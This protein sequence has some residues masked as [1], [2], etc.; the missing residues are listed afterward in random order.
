MNLSSRNIAFTGFVHDG[1][2]IALWQADGSGPEPAAT[3]HTFITPVEPITA[4][5]Y[6]ASRDYVDVSARGGLCATGLNGEWPRFQSALATA[7]RDVRDLVIRLP[8]T[9]AG[10]DREG[11]DWFFRD[12][13]ET[14]F[15]QPQAPLPLSLQANAL[16]EFAPPRLV[17]TEDYRNARD[18]SDV[19]ISLVSDTVAVRPAPGALDGPFA[20]VVEGF[21]ADLAG[22]PVRFVVDAIQLAETAFSGHGRTNARFAEI[23]SARV[24]VD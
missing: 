19:K 20:G 10:P 16:L 5:Y 11:E 17:L 1:F 18:F 12:G 21:L 7:R 9:T 24:E 8:L 6:V 23:P 2:G 15:L 22:R 14:R 13:V 4:H 3:G